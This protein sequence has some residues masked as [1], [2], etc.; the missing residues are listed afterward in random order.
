MADYCEA[1]LNV[2]DLCDVGM[3]CCV[4]RNSFGDNIPPNLIFP[5]KTKS[6]FTK[7]ESKTTIAPNTISNKQISIPTTTPKPIPIKS[8][9]GDCVGTFAALF[10]ENIDSE[11]T[12]PDDDTCCIVSVVECWMLLGHNLFDLCFQSDPEPPP[13]PLITTTTTTITPVTRDVRPLCPGYCLLTIMI[14]FCTRPDVLIPRTSNCQK[15]SICCDN[16][17]TTQTAS[18]PKPQSYPK[19]TTIS[20][21]PPCPGSCIVTYL[22]FTCF[23]KCTVFCYGVTKRLWH[24]HFLW[25][26][27][28]DDI[29][30]S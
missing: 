8:C 28:L 22:S 2:K 6:S 4:S 7:I 24:L 1:I 14:G 20:P 30:R 15:G 3:R 11:A 29:I 17:R 5:N 19:A 13:R 9:K 16:T 10:C 27:S 21:L 12:C 25:N 26:K 18:K 23:S